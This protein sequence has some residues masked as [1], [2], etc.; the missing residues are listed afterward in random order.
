[1]PIIERGGENP[2]ILNKKQIVID[3]DEYLEKGSYKKEKLPPG[4]S[5][6]DGF[7]KIIN[8]RPDNLVFQYNVNM[9]DVIIVTPDMFVDDDESVD[10]KIVSTIM[11]IINLQLT[12]GDD[13]GKLKFPD[14]FKG[15][16]DLFD[17]GPDKEDDTKPEKNSMFISL[18]VDYI[19]FAIDFAG[20]FFTGG[21]FFIEKENEDYKPILF[22]DGIRVDGSRLAVNINNQDFDKIKNKFINPD[23]RLEFDPNGRIV[24]PRN[25]GLTS[26]NITAKGKNS[27]KL[28]L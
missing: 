17:R 28:D 1:L 20:S 6:F 7:E 16:K 9:P 12:A 2:I 5:Y 14:M 19:S 22:P 10:S 23:F 24:I 13:G 26:V 8:A 27:I 25:I 4:G 11:L 3:N 21:K 18:N 15:Q